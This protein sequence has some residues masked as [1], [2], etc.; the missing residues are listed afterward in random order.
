MLVVTD[1]DCGIDNLLS[2]ATFHL[3]ACPAFVI[4]E[5]IRDGG[6][7]NYDISAIAEVRPFRFEPF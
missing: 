5:V 4:T 3:Y 6:E 1:G 7:C 2:G